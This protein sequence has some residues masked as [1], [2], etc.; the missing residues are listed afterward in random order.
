VKVG[1]CQALISETSISKDVEVF[2]CQKNL[3]HY[4]ILSYI[5]LLT[6][7]C[8]LDQLIDE[9]YSLIFRTIYSI[10]LNFRFYEDRFTN[11]QVRKDYKFL[12][13][14]ISYGYHDEL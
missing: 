11:S 9:I 4:S 14:H 5:V 13:Y 10:L 3:K 7:K 6:R 12:P 2:F 1:H 8:S